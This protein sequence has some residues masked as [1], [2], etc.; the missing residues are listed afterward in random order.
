MN[1]KSVGIY[2]YY[3]KPIGRG[4]FSIIYKGYNIYTRQI[5]A[6]KKIIKNIGQDYVN[7]EIDLMRKMVHKNILK[8]YDVI[9]HKNYFYLILEYC[10]QGDLKKYIDLN[11]NN[12]NKKNDLNYINQ[13]LEG[14]KYLYQNKIIHRDIKPNNI[15][16]HN[17]NIY[18]VK[19]S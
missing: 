3:P 19:K 10:N 16:I 13:I 4:S 15:L 1:Y 12:L 14:F 6:I 17:E 5:V 9:K 8:L 11:I 18:I 7:R 2:N